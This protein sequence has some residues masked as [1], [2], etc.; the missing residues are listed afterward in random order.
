MRRLAPMFLLA[1][2][3]QADPTLTLGNDLAGPDPDD[4]G[5]ECDEPSCTSA[6]DSFGLLC[7]TCTEEGTSSTECLPAECQTVDGCLECTDPQ[8][9]T[10]TDCSQDYEQIPMASISLVGDG[11]FNP[12]SMVWGHPDASATTCRYPG[13]DSCVVTESPD[14]ER[15]LR[16]EEG[17]VVCVSDPDEPLPDPLAERPDDVPGPGACVHTE[18]SESVSCTTCTREDMSATRTCRHAAEEPCD[19]DPADPGD[20]PSCVACTLSDGTVEPLCYPPLR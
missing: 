17:P 4:C 3:C 14:G 20:D 10:A 5:E 11:A 9:R 13:V 19:P 16:C 6:V 8:D 1:A 7:T 12:C 15:C 2:A 18:P